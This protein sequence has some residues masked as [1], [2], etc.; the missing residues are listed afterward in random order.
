MKPFWTLPGLIKHLSA[1]VVLTVSGL[2]SAMPLQ[3][4]TRFVGYTPAARPLA[5]SHRGCTRECPENTLA[6]FDWADRLGAD[7]IE[8]DLR[9]TS[10]G[11]L[12][13]LHDRTVNRTTDG[14]GAIRNLTLDQVRRLNAGQGQ[15]IPTADEVFSFAASRHIRLLLDIKDSATLDPGHLL[16]RLRQ[17]QIADQVI[18]GTRSLRLLRTLES[19]D[20]DLTTLAFISGAGTAQTAIDSGADIIRLWARWTRGDPELVSSIQSQGRR[21]FVTA[22]ALRMPDL[23]ELAGIGVDGVITDYPGDVLMLKTSGR[24][25]YRSDR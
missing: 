22:G 5:V 11:Q 2:L 6:A 8:L 20:P 10:D 14:A 12:V 9:T 13:V 17:H 24:R 7:V 25:A 23:T 19:L 4:E 3:A 1:A 16:D 15:R 18:I 21:V